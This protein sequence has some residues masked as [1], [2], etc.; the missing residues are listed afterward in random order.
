[1]NDKEQIQIRFSEGFNENEVAEITEAFN[2]IAPTKGISNVRIG[3]DSVDSQIIQTAFLVIIFIGGAIS[4][5]FFASLGTDLYEKMKKALKTKKKP[6]LKFEMHYKNIRI[7][8]NAKP[9]SE[10]EWNRI[11][12]SIGRAEE[13]ALNEIEKDINIHGL[14]IN[15]NV[16]VDGYWNL[17]KY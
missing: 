8:I 4:A 6:L 17:G 10:E 16:N 9:E 3:L 13:I 14:I 15:Y 7:D 2:K 1:M 12:E 11:F 5:G